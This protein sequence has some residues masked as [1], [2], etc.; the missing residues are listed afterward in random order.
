MHKTLQALI[1]DVEHALYQSAGPAVQIYAQ[2]T[3]ARHINEGFQHCYKQRFWPQFR[4]RE[5]RTLNG[6]TGHVT[7]PFTHIADWEDI[8]HVF[9]RGSDRPLPLLPPSYNTLDDPVAHAT[10]RYIEA[11]GDANL[12]TVYPIVAEGDILVVG[13]TTNTTTYGLAD[14]VPFDHIA[15]VHYAAWSYFTDDGSNP[16]SALKHQGLFESRMKKIESDSD[17]HAIE[18]NPNSAYIPDRWYER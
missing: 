5:T 1:T 17:S 9:R 8:E 15:L 7:A 18:L 11:T 3:I 6:V 10:A 12:F 4:K 14:T 13:R 2:D 16:A